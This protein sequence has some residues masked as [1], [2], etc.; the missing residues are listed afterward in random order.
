[1]STEG[2]PVDV[3]RGSWDA[4][5]LR[6]AIL[7]SRFHDDITD[8]LLDGALACLEEHGAP[9]DAADV[10]RVP[11]A[12]DLPQTAARVVGTGRHDAVIA[13]GCVIRGETPHFE[14]V[15]AHTSNGLGV[16]ARE[17]H[18]PVVFGVLTTDDREQA[19][20]RSGQGPDN[21]G[22]QAGMAALELVDVYRAL[23]G[24]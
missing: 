23:E 22:Y 17:A 15:C 7:A 10:I 16:V 6:I 2:S 24:R 19:L 3:V 9:A 5:Q 21:K 11:G 13:L 12:W 8:R 18:I 14:Y 20:T 1:M 4:S